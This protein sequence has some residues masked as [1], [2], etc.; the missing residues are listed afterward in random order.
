MQ[1]RF[2]L[3]ILLIGLAAQPCEAWPG[4][5]AKPEA[6]D[7]EKVKVEVTELFKA[8]AEKEEPEAHKAIA[9]LAV[10]LS[11]GEKAREDWDRERWGP[12]SVYYSAISY[13]GFR[14]VFRYYQSFVCQSKSGCLILQKSIPR[15]IALMKN[16]QTAEINHLLRSLQGRSPEKADWKAWDEWWKETGKDLF[17]IPAKIDY[18]VKLED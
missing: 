9:K 3:S 6:P 13:F 5:L 14:P 1:N 11:K 16:G 2:V 15:M 10:L 7:Y 12:E 18:P 4:E 17:S 8:V